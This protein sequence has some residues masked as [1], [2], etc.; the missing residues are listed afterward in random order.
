M[1][2]T[3]CVSVLLPER[4]DNYYFLDHSVLWTSWT[5][6][7]FS[8]PQ[9]HAPKL[10]AKCLSLEGHDTASHRIDISLQSFENF[11]LA[12]HTDI[13]LPNLSRYPMLLIAQQDIPHRQIK[14]IKSKLSNPHPNPILIFWTKSWSLILNFSLFRALPNLTFSK[15]L[16]NTCTDN[17]RNNTITG[18]WPK[19]IAKYFP[20]NSKY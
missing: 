1:S 13:S 11:A 17:N 20:G 3:G 12:F 19:L 18:T 16:T 10:L 14:I 4:W 15:I 7:L 6:V 9:T 5:K 2:L 8:A